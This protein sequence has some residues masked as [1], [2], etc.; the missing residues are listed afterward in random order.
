MSS[1]RI[2]TLKGAMD[3][4]SDVIPSAEEIRDEF[5]NFIAQLLCGPKRFE[6]REELR[7]KL[8]ALKATLTG[9]IITD[10]ILCE[11]SRALDR[12]EEILG[13]ALCGAEK[14]LKKARILV[15]SWALALGAILLD[16]RW[17][18]FF[19]TVA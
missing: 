15:L 11:L 7:E 3:Y 13:E 4:I 17:K 1:K 14:N 9:V 18:A 10:G 12:L 19:E 8:I 2:S 16:R 5:G 6:N